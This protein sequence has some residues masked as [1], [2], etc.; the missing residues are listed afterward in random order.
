[1]NLNISQDNLNLLQA[2]FAEHIPA[3]KVLAFGSRVNGNSTE[4]SDLDIA[5]GGCS[6]V[7]LSLL[8]EALDESNL[9]FRVDVLDYETI[10]HSFRENILINHIV[11][12]PDKT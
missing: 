2:I 1:M 12:Y 7:E 5:V 4:S 6:P 8:R 11:L 9:P 10:P 3:G